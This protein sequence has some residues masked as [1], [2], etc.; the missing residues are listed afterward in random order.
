MRLRGDVS[1]MCPI[2]SRY[3]SSSGIVAHPSS[4]NSIN[5]P[6]SVAME[7]LSFLEIVYDDARLDADDASLDRTVRSPETAILYSLSPLL[8]PC[9]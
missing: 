7:R 1:R 2:G 6:S 8:S 4:G 5:S 3:R 9:R